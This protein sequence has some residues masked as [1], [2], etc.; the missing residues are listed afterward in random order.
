[1]RHRVAGLAVEAAVEA[2]EDRDVM[3]AGQSEGD[4]AFGR[5]GM[6]DGGDGSI[7]RDRP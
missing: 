2:E 1:M 6:R 4:F 3:P 5:G 7:E